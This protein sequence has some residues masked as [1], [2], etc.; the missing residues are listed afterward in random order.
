MSKVINTFILATIGIIFSVDAVFLWI[1]NETISSNI[2]DWVKDGNELV[3]IGAVVALST[4]FY[5][6]RRKK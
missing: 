2:T 1:G 3:F 5:F 6:G 4:H